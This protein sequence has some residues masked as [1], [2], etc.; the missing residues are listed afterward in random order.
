M[1]AG[2]AFSLPAILHSPEQRDGLT[3]APFRDG[4]EISWVYRDT[5]GDGPGAAFLRYAAGAKV[6][7]HMH[8]GYEHILVLEGAQSDDNGRHEAGDLVINPPGTTHAVESDVGCVV[9]AI[10]EKPVRFL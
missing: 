6:P 2:T 1:S 9:L 3:W 8:P 5:Q 10:W 7:G 4:I